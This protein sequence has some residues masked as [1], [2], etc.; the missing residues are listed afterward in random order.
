MGDAMGCHLQD[1]IANV[2]CLSCLPFLLSHL[3]CWKPAALMMPG[4]K[5]AKEANSHGVTK[6]LSATA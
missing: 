1:D 2:W 5:E 6:A 3:F 4:G